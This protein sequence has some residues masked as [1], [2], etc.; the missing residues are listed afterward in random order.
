MKNRITLMAAAAALLVTA[1]PAAAQNYGPQQDPDGYYSQS[2]QRGFYDRNGT[3]RQMRAQYDQRRGQDERQGFG[4]GARYDQSANYYRQGE[5][6][7]SCRRGNAVAGTIFGAAAGGVIG[8][9]VSHGN[10]GAVVGGAVLGGLLGNTVSKDI[11][12]DDQPYA[13]RT[14]S[15]G[16]NG[17][18]GRRYEWNHGQSRGFF[19]PTR[20]YQRSGTQCRDFTETTYRSDRELTHNGTACRNSDG[21]WRFD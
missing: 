5:Y 12:C 13:F 10:G 4:A 9:A 16:L 7:Q 2:D 8:S 15:Q 6:E 3:Y 18:V 21:Q 14:Y 1:L 19:Q 17:D 11:D 20:D